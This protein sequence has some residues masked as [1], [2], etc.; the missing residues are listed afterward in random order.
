MMKMMIF[1]SCNCMIRKEEKNRRMESNLLRF[2]SGRNSRAS[3]LNPSQQGRVFFFFSNDCIALF[4]TRRFFYLTLSR[5]RSSGVFVVVLVVP[6]PS[7]VL[8]SARLIDLQSEIQQM[9]QI[10]QSHNHLTSWISFGLS[11]NVI[12]RR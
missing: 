7:E 1:M 12:A 2:S 6:E 5:H 11:L 10:G 8:R 9:L 4:A 3:L